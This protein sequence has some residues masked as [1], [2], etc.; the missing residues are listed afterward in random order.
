MKDR[1]VRSCV[2]SR[3]TTAP[4]SVLPL[5]SV[6]T[7]L[8]GRVDTCGLQGRNAIRAIAHKYPVLL[9]SMSV[10]CSVAL[11]IPF[12]ASVAPRHIQSAL[13]D[14]QALNSQEPRI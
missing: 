11:R 13:L 1:I 7:P 8:T 14:M 6:T 3:S 4:V 5:L 10:R 12:Y 9:D 2:F